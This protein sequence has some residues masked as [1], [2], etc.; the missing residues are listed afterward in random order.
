MTTRDGLE[1]AGWLIAAG[2]VTWGVWQ[3][4]GPHL[5]CAVDRWHNRREDARRKAWHPQ[6]IDREIIRRA[7]DKWGAK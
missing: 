3:V 4:A 6:G 1:F 5:W 2:A 7:T